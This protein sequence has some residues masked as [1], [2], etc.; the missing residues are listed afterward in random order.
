MLSWQSFKWTTYFLYVAASKPDKVI[1][2]L[3]KQPK[4]GKFLDSVYDFGRNNKN[5]KWFNFKV[6]ISEMGLKEKW[7]SKDQSNNR[8]V[9]ILL[10]FGLLLLMI[11]NILLVKCYKNSL[12]MK[13]PNWIINNDKGSVFI[14]E[15][16]HTACIWFW[17]VKDVGVASDG[18]F[19]SYLIG[20]SWYNHF[21][22]FSMG[23]NGNNTIY[24][25][26]ST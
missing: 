6:A 22:S 1:M 2:V 10:F 11:A 14:V 26:L 3:Q 13:K 20:R 19:S 5:K 23:G 9:K 24:P 8:L 25:L 12:E 4:F 15:T 21:W 16:G 7:I 18:N 17:M